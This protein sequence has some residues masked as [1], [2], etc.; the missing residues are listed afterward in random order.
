MFTKESGGKNKKKHSLEHDAG[1]ISGAEFLRA[2]EKCFILSRDSS[3]NESALE[4]QTK[5]EIPISIGL[6]TLINLLAIDN[7]GTDIDPTNCAPLF[8]SIIKLV[9]IPERDVFRLEDLSR[10]LDVETQIASLPAEQV[11]DIAKE[12]HHNIVTGVSEEDSSLQ[13]NRR[14]Q[15]AKIEF[16]S[17]L[18]KQKQETH[19][20]KEEKEKYIKRS[21][22]A[23]QTLRD[24]YT[25]QLQDKYENNIFWNRILFFIVFPII[26]LLIVGGIIYLQTEHESLWESE[27]INLGVH[28]VAWFILDFFFVDKK[29][30]KRYSEQVSDIAEK[31]E[32]KIKDHVQD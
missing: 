26:S 29:L 5:N 13:L 12:L 16:Q 31:V 10:I 27:L 14:F 8:A 6:D 15:S 21:D 19:F 17:D 3:I 32:Q 2:T 30:R 4:I 11:I 7:G 28:I 1:I 22:K 25:T 9:L 23:T 18:H 24:E 20:E